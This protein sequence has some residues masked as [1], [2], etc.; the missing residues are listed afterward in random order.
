MKSLSYFFNRYVLLSFMMSY[1]KSPEH[2]L[3]KG[4]GGLIARDDVIIIKVNSQWDERGAAEASA[5]RKQRPR[6]LGLLGC[7]VHTDEGR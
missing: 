6:R 1:P 2:G 3:I 4:P 5:G 7:E